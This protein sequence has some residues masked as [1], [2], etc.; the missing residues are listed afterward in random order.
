[1]SDVLRINWLI[2]TVPSF[3]IIKRIVVCKIYVVNDVIEGKLLLVILKEQ[4][5]VNAQFVVQ[6]CVNAGWQW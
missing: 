2:T 6:Q 1:L 5:G 4:N 3:Q